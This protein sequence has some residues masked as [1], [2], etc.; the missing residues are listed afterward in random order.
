MLM[1]KMETYPTR[2]RALDCET[3]RLDN[4]WLCAMHELQYIA[5]NDTPAPDMDM[6]NSFQLI[7]DWRIK[8]VLKMLH[9]TKVEIVDG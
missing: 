2:C 7:I 5:E 1:S 8:R 4:R 3:P 9:G 6:G